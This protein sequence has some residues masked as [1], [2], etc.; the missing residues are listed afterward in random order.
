MTL[1]QNVIRVATKC[2]NKDSPIKDY[3]YIYNLKNEHT[4]ANWF[5]IVY[6]K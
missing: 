4:F 6:Y 1:R 5:Q 3:K 2:R